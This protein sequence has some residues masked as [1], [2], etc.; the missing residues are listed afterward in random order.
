MTK[1]AYYFSHD[2]NARNDVKI[3]KLRRVLGLEGYAIYFCLIEILREQKD[4]KLPIESISDI[5]YDL[6]TS[7]EKIKSVISGFDL[8][9]IEG[10]NEDQKFF[11]A[12]LLRSMGEYNSKK[13]KLSE[14]GKKGNEKRWNQQ[15]MLLPQSGG[16]HDPIALKKIKE[17]E[18]YILFD[19]FW[20][21]YGYKVSRQEAEKAWNKLVDSDKLE[22]ISKL[23]KWLEQF[24]IHTWKKMPHASTFLN[25]R[26]WL[27]EISEQ[28][29]QE[30]SYQPQTPN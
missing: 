9:L 29:E 18:K 2:A 5:A 17:K 16:D 4:H 28:E 19:N 11:S 10:Q 14:S 21:I 7:E 8:F 27:D 15:L 13:L 22:C 20:G 24:K 6:H 30:Q 23:P 3:V 12:R 25:G 1:E 26:R